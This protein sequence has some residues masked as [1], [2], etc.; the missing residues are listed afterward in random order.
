MTL[1][2]RSS[3]PL[4][5]VFILTAGGAIATMLPTVPQKATKPSREDS[6]WR[7]TKDGWEIAWW[8][9]PPKTFHKP[10]VHP[11]IVVVCQLVAAVSL[12][13]LT[14]R[15]YPQHER[16]AI[17]VT[18]NHQARDATLKTR[19]DLPGVGKHFSP[20]LEDDTG[21]KHLSADRT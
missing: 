11:L 19:H 16:G 3:W 20:R 17:E 12:L 6:F 7:R 8:L 14:R 15:D 10:K 21:R 5:I 2:L 13:V 1:R 9:G 18:T 4:V